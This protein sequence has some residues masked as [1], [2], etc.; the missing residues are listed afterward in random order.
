[1]ME[2]SLKTLFFERDAA[3]ETTQRLRV[4]ET[5]VPA[6]ALSMNQIQRRLRR[7]IEVVEALTACARAK[8]DLVP[9]LA[10]D[11]A[12]VINDLARVVSILENLEQLVVGGSATQ[13]M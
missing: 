1:M 7:D 5:D 8:H 10:R 9:E 4:P 12:H 13:T 2:Q 6:V 11:A 3:G